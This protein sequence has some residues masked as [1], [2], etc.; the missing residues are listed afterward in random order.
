MAITAKDVM[1]LRQKTGLGMME[2]KEA[3]AEVDGDVQQAIDLLRQR[4]LAKMDSRAERTSAEGRIAA[5]VSDDGSKGALVEINTETDFTASNEMFQKMAD[6][7]AQEALQ[8]P[9]GEVQL[10]DTMKAAIDEVRLT[11]KENVQFARGAVLGGPGSSVG[12]YVHF[13]GKVGV[14]IELD[15]KVD[16]ALLKDLCMHIS[17]VSPVP[18]GVTE[19][20]VPA[21]VVAKEREIA[22]AQAIESGKPEQIAEK[23]VEGKIRKFYDENVLLRQPFIKDDKKQ[24]KD[25]LPKGVTIRK[26]VRYQVGG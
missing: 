12:H 15:G 3:L 8:G 6:T 5:A 17:A 13:T 11:T 2:C 14:L 20:E 10:N 23:M 1:A 7:V 9:A 18:L 26:F 25:L 19:D 24:I 4:G 22:K 16:D 21:D